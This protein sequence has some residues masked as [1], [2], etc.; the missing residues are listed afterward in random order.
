MSNVSQGFHFDI[1]YRFGSRES[2]IFATLDLKDLG[3]FA[4]LSEGALTPQL[5]DIWPALEV[6]LDPR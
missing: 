2:A 3:A 5:L 6:D 1:F 4:C